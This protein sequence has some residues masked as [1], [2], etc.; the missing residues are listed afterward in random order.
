MRFALALLPA[1][2]IAGC[3][4]PET[5]VRTALVD[6]GLPRPVAACMAARM[7]DRL[8][9]AQLMRLS[10]LSGIDR[11]RLGSMTIDEFV[12]RTRALQDPE[13]LSVVTSSGLRCALAA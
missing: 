4:T 3:S 10:R 12:R 6:A 5:R 2:M 11:A 1:L 13:I 8:S 7:V 9:L